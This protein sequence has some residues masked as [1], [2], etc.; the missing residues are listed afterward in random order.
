MGLQN[1]T[2]IPEIFCSFRGLQIRGQMEQDC[3]SCS[4]GTT[5]QI[6]KEQK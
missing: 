3:K 5:F 6:F 1:T 2:L 4:V